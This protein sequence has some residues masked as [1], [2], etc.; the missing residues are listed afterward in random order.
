[1][2]ESFFA[3][4]ECELIDRRA[5]K[6]LTEARLAV[7]T[8]IESW[9]NPL[10]LHSGFGYQLGLPITQQL[11]KETARDKRRHG[12]EK[13]RV[14]HRVLRTCGQPC[15][16]ITRAEENRNLNRPRKWGKSTCIGGGRSI[17]NHDVI[18]TTK[19]VH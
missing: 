3:S 2:A 7:F 1:M 18:R 14:T 16:C 17:G 19:C 5:W 10:R 11:R 15:A 13:R 9:Y 6:T 12:T 4:L 8:W